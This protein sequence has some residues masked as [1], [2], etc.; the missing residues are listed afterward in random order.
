MEHANAIWNAN[1]EL[2]RQVK[3]QIEGVFLHYLKRFESAEQRKI[4]K[5]G[6]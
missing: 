5:Q 6:Q 1:L 3:N 2:Q 4:W